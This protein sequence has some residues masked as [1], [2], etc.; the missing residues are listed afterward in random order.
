V[1]PISQD[2]WVKRFV[3]RL[4]SLLQ[5][6]APEAYVALGQELWKRAGALTPERIAELIFT[7]VDAAREPSSDTAPGMLEIDKPPDET[8]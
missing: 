5:T 3:D 2:E 4:G 7:D 8:A 1:K 6:E